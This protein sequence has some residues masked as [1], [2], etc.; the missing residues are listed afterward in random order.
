M[1]PVA[2]KDAFAGALLDAVVATVEATIP[3]HR[4]VSPRNVHVDLALV[5]GIHSFKQGGVGWQRGRVT[6]Q[7]AFHGHRGVQPKQ[8][9][10][11]NFHAIVAIHVHVPR[12]PHRRRLAELRQAVGH[13]ECLNVQACAFSHRYAIEGHVQQ[14]IHPW[15]SNQ[16]LEEVQIPAP[17][18][19]PHRHRAIHQRR[20]TRRDH[21]VERFDGRPS[22]A[23]REAC[24]LARR[25]VSCTRQRHA[26]RRISWHPTQVVQF[27]C[28]PKPLVAGLAF[29]HHGRVR[30]AL[31]KAG[32]KRASLVK[33]V[34]RRRKQANQRVRRCPTLG[35]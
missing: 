25:E 21:A 28:R 26:P 8:R 30:G 22:C 7:P 19:V 2:L 33:F 29:K 24:H 1:H 5:R 13:V 20:P 16:R 27:R 15:F 17:S 9:L 11:V 10:R 32:P 23:K 6:A 34:R 4:A 12:R 18:H 35:L 14:Q 31:H 3:I